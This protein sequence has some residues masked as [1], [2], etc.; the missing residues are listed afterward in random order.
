MAHIQQIT[1]RDSLL[2]VIFKLILAFLCM[3]NTIK[4]HGKSVNSSKQYSEYKL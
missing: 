3:L 2:Q 4:R 1:N